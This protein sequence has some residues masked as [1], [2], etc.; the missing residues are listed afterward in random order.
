MFSPK[1]QSV[2]DIEATITPEPPKKSK[3]TSTAKCCCKTQGKIHPYCIPHKGSGICEHNRQRWYCKDCGGG[4][5][6][7]HD[8]E[9]SKCKDC[10]GSAICPHNRI[11][12]TCKDCGG[13]GIC[14][15]NRRRSECKD[16]GGGGIC[17]HSRRRSTCK[18]CVG[19]QICEHNKQKACCKICGGSA[20]CKTPLCDIAAQKKFLGHCARC[21]AYTHPDTAVARN[22]KT[23]QNTVV[24]RIKSEFTGLT[25]VAD[26]RVEGGCSGRRPDLLV[27][28]G[29]YV[30]I[31]EVDEHKHN[32]YD[33]ICENKRVM[34]ISRD[35]GHRPVVF[36][37]FNPDAYTD[38]NGKSVTSCWKR[39]IWGLVIVKPTKEV[40]WEA[41]IDKL[42]QTIQ[43][44]IDKPPQKTV[45]TIELFY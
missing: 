11:R 22:Y 6:C 35:L 12:R 21:F 18:D 16:C 36:I 10:G 13:G 44:F 7:E 34:E 15:H 33:R 4:G 3:K 31:I 39:N 1:M 5:I 40:E 43:H 27:D 9:R 23:K 38:Q 32:T 26:N 25:W 41:R 42:K 2:V 45:E 14:A 29:P 8:R 37:R 28:F 17:E 24:D 20:L 19:S 30:L